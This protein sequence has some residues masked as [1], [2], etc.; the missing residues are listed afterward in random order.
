MRQYLTD[1]QL[2]Q[3][4][5]QMPCSDIR[6]YAGSAVRWAGSEG[7]G[8][9]VTRAQLE[10]QQAQPWAGSWGGAPRLFTAL[11]TAANNG[12]DFSYR[13]GVANPF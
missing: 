4:V 8:R 3:L 11:C 1:R 13:F 10:C 9:R 2:E 12:K 5:D 7:E 6:D